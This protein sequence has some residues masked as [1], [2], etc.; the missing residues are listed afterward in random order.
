MLCGCM[1]RGISRIAGPPAAAR[2]ENK[3]HCPNAA[4]PRPGRS[5]ILGERRPCFP[6]SPGC[7]PKSQ[8]IAPMLTAIFAAMSPPANAGAL[9]KP[10]LTFGPAH[11][12]QM[13]SAQRLWSALNVDAS[14]CA[15]SPARLAIDFTHPIEF[16][17]ELAFTERFAWRGGQVDVAVEFSIK[18]AVLDYALGTFHRASVASEAVMRIAEHLSFRSSVHR[19]RRADDGYRRPL[20]NGGG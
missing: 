3:T 4:P 14:R 20:S 18:E 6:S 12:S 15:S 9:C 19:S 11:F 2:L 16:G 17:P 10:S 1:R 8:L 13:A 5:R 7:R